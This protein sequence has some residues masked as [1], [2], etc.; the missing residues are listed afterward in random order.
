MRSLGCIGDS[1]SIVRVGIRASVK[2]MRR[3]VADSRMVLGWSVFRFRLGLCLGTGYFN[4]LHWLE[5]HMCQ[6]PPKQFSNA[7]P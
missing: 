4:A 1:I 2:S 7:V 6:G 3:G 5:G